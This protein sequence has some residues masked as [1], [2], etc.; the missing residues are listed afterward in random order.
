MKKTTIFIAALLL[1]AAIYFL[2]PVRFQDGQVAVDHA[3]NPDSTVMPGPADSSAESQLDYGNV[4]RDVPGNG[5]AVENSEHPQVPKLQAGTR[6]A[7]AEILNTSSDGL[8]EK[9]VNGVTSVNL[10]GRFRTAP[11]ATIDASGEVHIT[12]YSH[13]PAAGQ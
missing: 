5:A 9:T 8:V 4:R 11:V 10:Q 1:G 12:D 7:L 2:T 6:E 3:S 13:L